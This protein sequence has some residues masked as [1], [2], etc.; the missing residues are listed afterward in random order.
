MGRDFRK[1]VQNRKFSGKKR[2]NSVIFAGGMPG[3]FPS[4][5]P[6]IRVQLEIIHG[7]CVL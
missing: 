3:K 6:A 5:P 1:F 4:I 2:G 7:F